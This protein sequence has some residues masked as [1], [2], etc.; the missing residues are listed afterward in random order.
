MPIGLLRVSPRHRIGGGPGQGKHAAWPR[1][2]TVEIHWSNVV[3]TLADV[4]EKDK[5]CEEG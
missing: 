4:R 5:R 1:L 2:G 3:E